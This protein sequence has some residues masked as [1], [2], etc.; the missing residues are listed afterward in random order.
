[1]KKFIYAML[2]TA[3]V[4][5]SSPVHAG[6]WNFFSAGWHVECTYDAQYGVTFCEFVRGNGGVGTGKGKGRK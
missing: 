6:W 2:L 4:L 3:C 5:V 1:M